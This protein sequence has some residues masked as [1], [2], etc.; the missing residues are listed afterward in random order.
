MSNLGRFL[1]GGLVNLG[2]HEG[3]ATNGLSTTGVMGSDDPTNRRMSGLELWHRISRMEGIGGAV[4]RGTRDFGGR[5][6][7]LIY[8]SCNVTVDPGDR[9]TA[10]N[11]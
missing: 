1:S 11:K 7:L 8:H 5:T 9:R 3:V 2:R 10:T 6:N 4:G